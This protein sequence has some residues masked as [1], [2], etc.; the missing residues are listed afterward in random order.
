VCVNEDGGGFDFL[1]FHHRMVDSFSKPGFRFLARWPSARAMQAA[2]RRIS[3]LTDRRLLFL[4]VEEV[5][6]HLNRYLTGWAGY[7]RRSGR[8]VGEVH[9]GSVMS[10]PVQQ[11]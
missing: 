3:E 10:M 8:V 11:R 2:R 5:V 1:G 4:P 7:F 9:R 6:T